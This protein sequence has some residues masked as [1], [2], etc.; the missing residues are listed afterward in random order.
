MEFQW[1]WKVAPFG[2]IQVTENPVCFQ[3]SLGICPKL[4]RWGYK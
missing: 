1:P 4:S 2:V 3:Q